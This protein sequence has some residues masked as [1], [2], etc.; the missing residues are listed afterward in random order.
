MSVL[1]TPELAAYCFQV[2]HARL[3]GRPMPPVPAGIPNDPSPIFVTF[4]VLPHED[5]RG[6][7]GN[8]SPS[9]LHKQLQDYAQIAAF[10]DTRF[11]PITLQELPKLACT[12][13]LLHSFE[14]C[15]T[16]DDWTVGKHGIR[17]YYKNYG[18][19]Y[20]PSVAEEQGWNH[21]QTMKSL[22]LKG[23]YRGPVDDELLNSL[24][25]SRYQVSLASV[26]FTDVKI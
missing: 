22:L 12:V 14:V 9:P 16:W 15:R 18:A 26:K 17:F 10:E 24:E 3:V 8:F 13:S 2:V 19:T 23:G 5:L 20:L 4:K 1:A 6:C 25:V 21:I 7:I 11:S